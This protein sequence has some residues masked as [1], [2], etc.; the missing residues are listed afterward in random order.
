M[1][2]AALFAI[3]LLP[4]VLSAQQPNTLTPQEVRDGWI[5]LWDGETDFGWEWHGDAVWTFRDGILKASS[6]ENGWL[7]TTTTFG[8]F[9][10]KLEFRTA[11]DG[12][13][14]IFLR[15][16][17]EGQPHRT[18]YELQIY[19]DQ[20]QGFNTGSL[21]FYQKAP[22][23]K[24][25]AD[26][27]N[28]YDIVAQG[29]HYKITLNG[30]VVLETDN[31]THLSGVIGLQ[32]NVDKPIEL[33]NLKL[34]PLG[35]ES[36]FNGRNLDGWSKVDRPNR[37][38]DHRWQVRDGVIHVEGGPGQI[39]TEQQFKNLALQLA[40]KTNPPSAD[41]HPNSG[42]FFRGTPGGFWTGYESQIRNEFAGDR[43]RPIDFGTGGVYSYQP[44]RRVI[45]SDGEWFTKTIIAYGRHISI[46]V[47][48]VQTADYEDAK[49]EGANSRKQANLRSGPIALQ[50]H[51]PTTNLDFR[52][53]RAAEIAER[54]IRLQ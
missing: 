34:K 54:P 43:A 25:I 48:G 21:V 46:W 24:L 33:R 15:S 19:D 51:D 38:G 18:G 14:G 32:Y 5:L 12:N 49:P 45:P 35:L 29:S 2:Y 42:V 3:L 37:A 7:G 10:L 31:P 39:E 30:K 17:R 50:A 8:D 1:K 26:Q 4:A 9:R 11:A 52:D 47:N 53:V 13:S 23:A 22:P 16:A 40:V 36:L 41:K 28:T 20:P 44:T 27:W 6:G